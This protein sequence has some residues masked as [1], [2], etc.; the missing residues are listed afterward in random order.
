[1]A[2]SAQTLMRY[3]PLPA[4]P[5]QKKKTLIPIHGDEPRPAEAPLFCANPEVSG[6]GAAAPEG[7]ASRIVRWNARDH[8]TG[9]IGIRAAPTN[10][11]RD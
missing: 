5:Q 1:M 3:R 4:E 9:R 7:Y 10:G 11:E 6:R 8:G 2:A